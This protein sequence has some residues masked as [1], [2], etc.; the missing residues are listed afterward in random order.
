MRFVMIAH[1]RTG[2]TVFR[3]LLNQN[4]SVYAYG[5]AF[6]P[7]LF[8]WGWYSY[9]LPKVQEDPSAILPPNRG[10]YLTPYLNSLYEAKEKPPIVA[11]GIDVKIP[12]A[13]LIYALPEAVRQCG[14]GVLHLR[15]KNTL[16]AIVS[17]ELAK[18]RVRSGG[19]AH[20]TQPANSE[21]VRLN[22]NWL[23]L[24][25]SEFEKQDEKVKWLYRHHAY[26]ELFYEDF[27]GDVG[28][29]RTCARLSEFLG[30]ELRGIFSPRLKKQNSSNVS[31]LIVN[32]DQVKRQFPQF[33]DA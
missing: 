18:R 28:W 1:Q 14:A 20:G 9:L 22:L 26:M 5:E 27:I 23:E 31:D 25:I 3:E 29:Q 30:A 24:R 17:Y 2:T 15:R 19:R 16:A 7:K 4:Q 33:F 21:P 10:R 6:H 8:K 12:Q 13:Q 32:A 11:V